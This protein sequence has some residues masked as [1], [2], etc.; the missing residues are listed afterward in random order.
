MDALDW[1]RRTRASAWRWLSTLGKPDEFGY[2]IMV[3]GTGILMRDAETGTLE[4]CGL[5]AKRII[6]GGSELAAREAAIQLVVDELKQTACKLDEVHSRI[7]V[8]SI[9]RGLIKRT[10]PAQI[11]GFVF[12]G[13]RAGPSDAGQSDADEGN[14]IRVLEPRTESESRDP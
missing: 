5:F 13:G 6:R 8:D 12:Y 1:C 7:V 2:I 11:R 9:K 4:E 10:A 3:H 14:E